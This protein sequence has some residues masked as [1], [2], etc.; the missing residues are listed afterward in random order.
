MDA[1]KIEQLEKEVERLWRALD[2]IEAL[3][4]APTDITDPGI[5]SQHRLL[6]IFW[7]QAQGRD[8]LPNF[9]RD[10]SFQDVEAEFAFKA[11]LEGAKHGGG[12]QGV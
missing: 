3:R 2:T 1:G 4:P 8:I 12:S 9:V 10:G 7:W 6:F 5:I 11:W